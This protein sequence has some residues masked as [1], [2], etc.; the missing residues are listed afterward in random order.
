VKN[1][2][3]RMELWLRTLLLE[4]RMCAGLVTKVAR[5]SKELRKVYWMIVV[6]PFVNTLLQTFHNDT[7]EIVRVKM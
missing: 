5:K 3:N 7:P 6:M 2:F 4:S 1:Y